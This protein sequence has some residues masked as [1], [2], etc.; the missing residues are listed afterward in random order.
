MEPDANGNL[1]RL[2]L[3]VS[4]PEGGR[5]IVFR[6]ATAAPQMEL[7]APALSKLIAGLA[8]AR[9]AMVPV[10]PADIPKDKL[11][12]AAPDPRYFVSQEPMRGGVMLSIRHPG[13]GWVS[14]HFLHAEVQT[15]IGLLSQWSVSP[16]APPARSN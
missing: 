14:F 11:V 13:F 15:M 12:D 3:E 1:K 2:K 8:R 7:D 16:D 4:I 10:V 9:A 5:V 6:L